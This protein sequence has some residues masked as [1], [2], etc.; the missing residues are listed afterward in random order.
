MIP[1]NKRIFFLRVIFFIGINCV[2][3]IWNVW[4]NDSEINLVG[5]SEVI[6]KALDDSALKAGSA[7]IGWKG[8][9]HNIHKQN[10]A[11]KSRKPRRK[12]ITRALDDAVLKIS[13]GYMFVRGEQTFRLPHPELGGDISKL[14]YP[15]KGEMEKIEAELKINPR[16][17][18]GG[19]YASSNLKNTTSKDEDWNFLTDEGSYIESYSITEQDTK[20][21]ASFWNANLY[22]RLFNWDDEELGQGL[23]DFLRIENLS[24]DVFGGYQYYQG[25]HIMVDP[26]TKHEL[27]VEGSWFYIPTPYN[28]GLNS[29][30]EVT[31]K[32][33]RVGMRIGGSVAEKSSSSLSI[34]YAWVKSDADGFWNVRDFTW[35]HRSKGYGS[36]LNIDFETQY[37]FMPNWFLGGGL[38]WMWQNQKESTYSG[39]FGPD[40][41]PVQNY[42][43]SGEKAR[44]TELSLFGVSFKMGYKW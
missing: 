32:G 24:L 8:K 43:F 15:I 13:L 20:S 40:G 10:D 28:T 38:H 34:A 6:S 42:S 12:V 14:T 27:M 19:R 4:S 2:L 37:Y 26:I 25:R 3:S 30:Y 31:Y 1:R 16:V 33:P 17:F 35:Q 39:Q 23:S 9:N 7:G 41:D 29:S 21:K 5:R 44:A 11:D 18:L 36:A 22:Y